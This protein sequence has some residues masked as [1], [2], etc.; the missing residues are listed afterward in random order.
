MGIAMAIIRDGSRY[1]KFKDVIGIIEK[2][3]YENI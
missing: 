3:N 1:V 2:F